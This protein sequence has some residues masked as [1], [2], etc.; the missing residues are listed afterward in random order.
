[1][2]LEYSDW[3]CAPVNSTLHWRMGS[4]IDKA[5]KEYK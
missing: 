1:M 3:V 2:I 5:N 4:V